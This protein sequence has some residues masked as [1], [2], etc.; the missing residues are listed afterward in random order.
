M[1]VVVGAEVAV[2]VKGVG[3]RE[4]RGKSGGEGAW[5]KAEACRAETSSIPAA[6]VKEE[7]K[8]PMEVGEVGEAVRG[9]VEEKV[10]DMGAPH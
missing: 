2:E 6:A 7:A 10:A 5:D 8:E 3:G 1:R 4:A 9:E